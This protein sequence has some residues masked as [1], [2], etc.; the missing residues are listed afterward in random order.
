MIS[1]CRY[2][3]GEY[4][5]SQVEKYKGSEELPEEFWPELGATPSAHK[6]YLDDNCDK[7]YLAMISV[8]IMFLYEMSAHKVHQ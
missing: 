6:V 7:V 4:L 2:L 5:P 1:C 8:T 3:L